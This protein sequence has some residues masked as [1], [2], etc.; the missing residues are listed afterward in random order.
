MSIMVRESTPEETENAI[1]DGT[2]ALMRP[3]MT[4]TDGLWVAMTR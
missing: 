4:L 2:L 1:R 3:V